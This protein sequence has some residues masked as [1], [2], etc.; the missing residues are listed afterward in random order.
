MSLSPI[1]I[2]LAETEAVP[3]AGEAHAETAAE[4]SGGLGAIGLDGRALLFQI[5]NFVILFWILK[6]VAYKP[7]LKMLEARRRKIEQGL[8]DAEAATKAAAEAESARTKLLHEAR[9]EADKLLAQARDE[10]AAT[11]K[12]AE[13]KAQARAE[14]IV[15]DAQSRTERQ[16]GE[17]RGQLRRELGGLVAAATEALIGTKLDAKKDAELIENALKTADKS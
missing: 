5:I 14:Q 16:A 17:V 7:V 13:T 12:T 11:V 3:V 15:A 2:Y 6:M 4:G 10:A 8:K 9:A 1:T